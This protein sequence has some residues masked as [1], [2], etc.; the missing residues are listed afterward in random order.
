MTPVCG[1]QVVPTT[2][3]AHRDTATTPAAHRDTATG[4]VCFCPL[5][6]GPTADFGHKIMRLVYARKIPAQI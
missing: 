2:P 5:M 6:F 3:A 1:M 4:T